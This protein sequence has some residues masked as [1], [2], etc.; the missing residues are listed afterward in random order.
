M[1]MSM[2][3]IVESR[4]EHSGNNT[5]G[6][7]SLE[8]A[9]S[10]PFVVVGLTS[11]LS[12][13]RLAEGSNNGGNEVGAGFVGWGG[14]HME[15]GGGAVN[16]GEGG[17]SGKGIWGGDEDHGDSGDAGGEDIASNLATSESDHAGTGN[18][19]GIV[20]LAKGLAKGVDGKATYD[21]VGRA[22]CFSSAS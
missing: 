2:P 8:W 17:D 20:I 15:L 4:A 10:D 3:F 12:S 9:F 22:E 11:G 14:V 13:P 19:S 6:N 21:R 5:L 18:G 16:T 7:L 1:D